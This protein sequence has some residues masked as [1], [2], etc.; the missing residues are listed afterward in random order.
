M[1]KY[2]VAKVSDI[3]DGG[4]IIVD[5]R[6]RSIGVFNLAGEFHAVL[7]RCPHG[8]A[9][10]CR[11]SMVGLLESDVPGEYRYDG[12][13]KLLQ[14]PWH[15]WEFDVT[16][17]QSYLDPMRMRVRHYDAE[18][19]KGQAVQEEVAAGDTADPSDFQ[20]AGELEPK[21]YG[22]PLEKGP[23]KAEL[24]PVSVEDDYVVVSMR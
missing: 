12:S 17:G 13:Q 20:I 7:N 8:G 2:V 16:T 19:T 18:V 14:C 11:G 15:G 21:P 4:R 5:I 6:G 23:Y 10:L 24:V 3:P 22:V 9:P 1:A